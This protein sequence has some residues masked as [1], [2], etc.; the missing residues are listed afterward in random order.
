MSFKAEV[1]KVLIS[2]PSDIDKEKNIIRNLIIDWNAVNS[3]EKNI[4]L[5]PISWETDTTPEVGDSPQEIINKQLLEKSDL[6][7]ALFWTRIGTPTENYISGTVEEIEKHIKAGKPAMI[8]FSKKDIDPD[9]FD[10]DQYEKLKSIKNKYS[11]R[12]IYHE[13]TDTDDFEK[14]FKKHLDMK[15]IR[16]DYFKLKNN[17]EKMN[18]KSEVLD[19]EDLSK[20]AKSLLKEGVKDKRGQIIISKTMQGEQFLT[21]G[22]TFEGENPRETAKWNS[23]IDELENNNLIKSIG[24]K[25]EVFKITKKGYDIADNIN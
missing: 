19:P 2:S 8:Y 25:G 22:K 14:K 10:N 23:A 11:D 5:L 9:Q 3:Y 15:I 21:N 24:E 20:E 18:T 7:I 13:Y 1:Y 16:S 6:L 4:V 12:G 17:F